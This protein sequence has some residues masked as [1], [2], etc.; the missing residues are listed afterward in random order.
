MA[1]SVLQ[2]TTSRFDIAYDG[3]HYTMHGE[4][5]DSAVGGFDWVIYGSDFH[6][7]DLSRKHLPIPEVT[8][9]A[10]LAH[11]KLE[12]ISRGWVFEV[13]G[14]ITRFGPRDQPKGRLGMANPE[15]A[16]SDTGSLEAHA[17]PGQ[18]PPQSSP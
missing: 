11:P 17:Q 9:L 15:P 3:E 14:D 12:L 18:N 2:V 13:D 4:A 10:V 7:T 8:R 16:A 5:L 1:F 6:F